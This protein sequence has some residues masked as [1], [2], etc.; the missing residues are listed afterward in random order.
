[1]IPPDVDI[2]ITHTPPLDTLDVARCGYSVGC[3]DLKAR[4]PD[5]TQCR[6]HVFGHIHEDHGATVMKR[7][8]GCKEAE[9]VSVN[10][11][12]MHNGQAVIVDLKRGLDSE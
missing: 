5:L 12:M 6:L 10:A 7:R 3:P 8:Y 2:L 4:L 9:F 1:M 11:A